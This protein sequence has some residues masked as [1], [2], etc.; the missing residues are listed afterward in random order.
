MR[1]NCRSPVRK[2]K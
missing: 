1:C 2:T